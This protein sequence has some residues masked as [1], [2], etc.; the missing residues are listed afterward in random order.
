MSWFPRTALILCATTVLGLAAAPS[1]AGAVNPVHHSAKPKGTATTKAKAKTTTAAPVACTARADSHTVIVRTTKRTKVKATR[2]HSARVVTTRTTV[3]RTVA[4]CVAAST[5]K[6]IVI[7][8]PPTVITKTTSVMASA[9]APV[10]PAP[11]P[12][13]D[14]SN[15]PVAPGALTIGINANT[16]GWGPGTPQEQDKVMQ[17]GV[18]WLR[19]ELDWNTV[20]TAP[21]QY[22]WS[23]YDALY[24]SAAQRGMT[25]LPVVMETPSWD[26][27]SPQQF[28]TDPNTYATFFA[29]V[30][31]RY[32]P[33]GTFWTENPSLTPT[34][35]PDFELWNEPYMVNADGSVYAHLV[36]AA[37]PAAH[38]ANP[39]AKVLIGS[40]I[41]RAWLNNQWV[42]WTDQLYNAVPTLNQDFDGVVVHPYATSLT[43]TTDDFAGRFTDVMTNVRA[44]FVAHGASDKPFWL[45]EIGWSTC[46]A[47]A[48]ANCV[49]E[50]Q[51]AALVS[52]LFSL[53]HTTYASYVRGVFLYHYND[54][55]NGAPDAYESYF[56]L[57]RPDGSQKPAYAAFQAAIAAND[58]S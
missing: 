21:G 55:P 27:P 47:G 45:T 15:A 18:R 46:P 26:G 33:G 29:A 40:D 20:E 3:R 50:D 56:G 10:A 41:Q 4:G 13:A 54:F 32:G 8:S 48:S 51:Q 24:T 37:G 1:I 6:T 25:I 38:A 34:P 36:A 23:H 43:A 58:N 16:Q 22:D 42:S 57:T 14:V 7:K 12:A 5:S 28:P 52:Q 2:S 17:T 30:A 53:L 19:E 11:A 35:S 44:D 9:A 31:A 49:S 39:A